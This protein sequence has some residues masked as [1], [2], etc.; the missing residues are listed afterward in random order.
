MDTLRLV[1]FDLDGTLVDSSEPI[2]EAILAQAAAEGL[3]L[4]DRAWACSRIGHPPLET[5]AE[6]GSPDPQATQAGFRSRVLPTLAERTEVLPG[7]ASTLATLARTD[8]VLAVATSRNSQ[9]A[10]ETLAHLGLDGPFACIAGRDRVEH[11]KPAP[12]LLLWVLERTG[13][14]PH[15]ALMIGDTTADVEAA[16][17]A[18]M[19]CWGVLGGHGSESSLRAAGS[20]R[21]LANG[22]AE[23]PDALAP[24][25]QR[26]ADP[27]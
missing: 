6:L 11:P 3:P 1:I 18:G 12:D 7:T 10:V 5:W 26:R 2:V 27:C 23:L 22:V 25:L 24:H 20:D 17:A 13:F 14:A 19:P 15:E 16:R 21:I 9:S 4:P 8:L